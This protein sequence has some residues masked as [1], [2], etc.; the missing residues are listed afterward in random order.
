[1]SLDRPSRDPT[2]PKWDRFPLAVLVELP[3]ADDDSAISG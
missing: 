2:S 1:V 3:I